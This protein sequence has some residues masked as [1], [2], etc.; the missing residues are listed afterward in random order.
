VE[1]ADPPDAA[2]RA[3]FKMHFA[4]RA[5]GD[6]LNAY[7]QGLFIHSFAL[8][9]RRVTVPEALDCCGMAD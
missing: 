6:A 9:G 4:E 5:F 3:M 2:Q 8:P 7:Q 1:S